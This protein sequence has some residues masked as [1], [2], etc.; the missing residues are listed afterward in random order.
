MGGKVGGGL[1]AVTTELE[2]K[3]ASRRAMPT[4]F[5]RQKVHAGREENMLLG[6]CKTD[7][8][9]QYSWGG[10]GGVMTQKQIRFN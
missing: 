6:C 3:E 9:W 1:E 4:L 7:F 5:S 2:F 8:V 10:H